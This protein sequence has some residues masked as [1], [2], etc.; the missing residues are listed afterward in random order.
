MNMFDM[1][2]KPFEIEITRGYN[3]VWLLKRPGSDIGIL[4][5]DTEN[6]FNNC[7]RGGDPRMKQDGGDDSY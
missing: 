4:F 1:K 7:V 5:V 3:N 6:H 2:Y